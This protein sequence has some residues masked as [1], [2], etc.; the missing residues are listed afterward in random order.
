MLYEKKN[1]EQIRSALGVPSFAAEQYFRQAAAYTN[2]QVKEAVQLCFDTEYAVKTGRLNA[3][4]A[5]E[6]VVLKLLNLKNK[7]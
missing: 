6:A 4:G 1:R 5:L 2:G 7:D 3:D